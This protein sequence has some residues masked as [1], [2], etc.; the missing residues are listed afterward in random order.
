MR[1]TKDVVQKLLDMNE[2]FEKT[3]YSRD[4]NFKATYHYLI[5]GGK[6]LVRSKGKTSWSDSNFDNTKVANLEQT[7]NFLRKAIDVLKTEG[8]K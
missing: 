1:L 5:K 2:G 7:R 4:R 6:L 8:I 3:T